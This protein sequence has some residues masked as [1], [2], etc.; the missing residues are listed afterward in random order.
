MPKRLDIHKFM[1]A[2]LQRQRTVASMHNMTPPVHTAATRPIVHMRPKPPAKNRP[3]PPQYH[4][5]SNM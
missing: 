5:A 1:D 3:A 2:V 4:G